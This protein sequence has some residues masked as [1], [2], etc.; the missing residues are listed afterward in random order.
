MSTRDVV[1]AMRSF[2]RRRRWRHEGTVV[3][4]EAKAAALRAGWH[5]VGEDQGR[6]ALRCGNAEVALRWYTGGGVPCVVDYAFL[7]VDGHTVDV[8]DHHDSGFAKL[9]LVMLRR[10]FV[11]HGATAQSD[12]LPPAVGW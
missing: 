11:R 4:R 1:V 9:Q 3:V 8:I 6:C 10:W 7:H 5:L 2:G 12:A